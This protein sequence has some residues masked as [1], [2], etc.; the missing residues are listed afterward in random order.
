VNK[1]QI[2][3]LLVSIILPLGLGAIAGMFTSQSVPEWYATLNRPSFNPPDW[4]FGPVWT[5]LY[6][7]MGFSFFLV[8]KQDAS[9]ERKLAILIFLLQLLLNFIWSFIFFYFN[10]IGFALVEIIL[11]WI[12]IVIML[13]LFYRIKPIASYL[14][15]PYLLWVTFASVLN[16]SYYLLN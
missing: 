5:T 9:K 6:I 4:I 10:M 3:K 15:I 2:L 12:S 7:L 1:T 8:W 13:V 11:L 16:A 14:N